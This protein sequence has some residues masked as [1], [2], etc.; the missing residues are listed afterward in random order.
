MCVSNSGKDGIVM[1]GTGHPEKVL[2]EM[3]FCMSLPPNAPFQS[4]S[5]CT[6]TEE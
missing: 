6:S 4:S 1:D 2:E 3:Q 5:P